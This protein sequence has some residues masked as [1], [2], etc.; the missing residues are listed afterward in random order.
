MGSGG[1]LL[2]AGTEIKD[3]GSNDYA[4]YGQ[5]ALIQNTDFRVLPRKRNGLFTNLHEWSLRRKVP[6]DS[7]TSHILGS[8]PPSGSVRRFTIHGNL[9]PSCPFPFVAYFI[10]CANPPHALSKHWKKRFTTEDS[11]EHGGFEI[12][13]SLCGSARNTQSCPFPICEHPPSL[14]SYGRTSLR[15]L[16]IAG[17]QTPFILHYPSKKNDRFASYNA[18]ATLLLRLIEFPIPSIGR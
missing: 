4:L 11:E 17:G 8:E 5:E 9:S 1:L 3:K 6:T 14:T 16:A 7:K 13:C 15:N 2:L 18:M 12:L 10:R